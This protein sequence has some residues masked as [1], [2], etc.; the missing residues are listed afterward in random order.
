MD[1]SVDL[2][3]LS[4]VVN[5]CSK[6]YSIYKRVPLASLATV[7]RHLKDLEERGYVAQEDKDYRATFKGLLVLTFWG[8]VR[9]LRSIHEAYPE[10]SQEDILN[11]VK[12][13]CHE[14]KRLDFLPIYN[15]E[16]TLF[17][18]VH[19]FKELE[20]FKGTEVEDVIARLCVKKCPSFRVGDLQM[21]LSYDGEKATCVAYVDGDG[22]R[23]FPEDIMHRVPRA[24]HQIEKMLYK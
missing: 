21:V 15:L 8:N 10:L 3:I 17:L 11:Y 1:S 22:G 9:A 12:L 18:L 20:K 13:F 24:F 4:A 14:V 5:G 7:Y 19:D 23:L 6:V 16:D 2:E